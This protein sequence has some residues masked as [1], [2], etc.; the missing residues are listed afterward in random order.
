MSFNGCIHFLSSEVDETWK[1]YN[2]LDMEAE[3][4]KKVFGWF[5][6]FLV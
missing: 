4:M 1:A 6:G 3:D 5:V 2:G